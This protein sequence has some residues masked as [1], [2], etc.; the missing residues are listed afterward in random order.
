MFTKHDSRNTKESILKINFLCFRVVVL[1]KSLSNHVTTNYYCK[2]NVD[3]VKVISAFQHKSKFN[4]DLFRKEIELFVF[5]SCSTRED[6]P[7][8]ESITTVGMILTKLGEF[9][10]R[11]T[12][13]QTD[14]HNFG[15]FIR[16]HVGTQKIQLNAQN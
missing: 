12:D 2:T 9:I 10:F 11:A 3:E 13:R 7:I 1:V 15:I 16:K 6:L 5:T 4:F 8:D 14:R